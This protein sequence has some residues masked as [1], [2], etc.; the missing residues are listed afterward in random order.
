MI[1]TARTKPLLNNES[2]RSLNQRIAAINQLQR[3]S[4]DGAYRNLV[5][6]SASPKVVALV[7]TVTRWKRYLLFLLHQF[8]TSHS[9]KLPSTLEQLLLLAL[10]ELV[11][12]DKP[13]HAVVNE[14]VNVA[15]SLGLNTKLTNGILRSVV[16]ALHA[17]PEPD[18]GNS[19]RNLAI[20]WS[21]PTWLTRRYVNRFGI[22]EAQKLLQNNNTTPQYCIRVNL[23]KISIVQLTTQ[24]NAHDISATQSDLLDDYLRVQSIGP[25]IREGYLDQGMCSVHDQSAGLVVALLDPQPNE[26]ILDACAA[27]GGK[28][29]AAACRMQGSGQVH[30]WD[31]HPNRL[32]KV[33]DLARKQGLKN[34]HVN[35]VNLLDS[36][37]FTADRVLLDAPCSGTGVMSKRADLRWQRGESDLL[38]LI[39]LQYNL[40]DA[41][42]A[43]VKVGG[44]LVYST[45]SIEPEENEH[46]IDA[47]L[48]RHPT[49][50]VE[51]AGDFLPSSVLTST[52]YMATLPH[53]HG[54]DGAFAVRLLKCQ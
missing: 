2:N 41:C 6:H 10:A 14:T 45:C 40:L 7:S 17:L 47:F 5:D 11:L 52:G 35:V 29:A 21:H 38:D 43:H 49:F 37:P 8:L 36:S 44:H 51:H 24:L 34:I 16:R 26:T 13:P 50:V 20:R 4:Q 42:V 1:P 33:K 48:E 9:K 28:A 31:K 23:Q 27:P 18:T 53:H 25:L 3:I 46:Q 22:H 54:M 30:A 15:R 32:K 19:I 39:K 12:L